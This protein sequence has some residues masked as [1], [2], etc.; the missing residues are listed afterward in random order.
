LV[1]AVGGCCYMEGQLPKV[2]QVV[3]DFVMPFSL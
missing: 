1:V 3:V 2:D